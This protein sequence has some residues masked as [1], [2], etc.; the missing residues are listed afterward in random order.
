VILLLSGYSLVAGIVFAAI[1]HTLEKKIV[2]QPF[3][4]L[5]HAFCIKKSCVNLFGHGFLFLS[6]DIVHCPI[7]QYFF[8]QRAVPAEITMIFA[9]F[10]IFFLFNYY[11]SPVVSA[12]F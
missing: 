2:R 12:F 9:T 8:D 1:H 10:D 3:F 11:V 4:K 7:Y 6:Q 5:F